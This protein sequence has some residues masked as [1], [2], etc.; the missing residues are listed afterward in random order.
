[1]LGDICSK[2]N[3]PEETCSC[4]SDCGC[5]D[6]TPGPHT[7]CNEDECKDWLPLNCAIWMGSPIDGTPIKKG[8]KAS[9]IILYL[10][11]R[12]TDLEK[13]LSDAGIS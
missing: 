8:T 4:N 7:P 2:C 10:L 11:K 9:E 12:I 6:Q 13:R 1:M 5:H 3:M